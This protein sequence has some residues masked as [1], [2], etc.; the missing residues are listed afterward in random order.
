MRSLAGTHASSEDTG[1]GVLD[2]SVAILDAVERGARTFTEIRD[3]TGYTKS[4]THR[5][6]A[7]LEAHAFLTFVGGQGYRF[8]PR[9]LRF[10]TTAMRDLPLRDLARTALVRLA[11]ATGESAQLYVLGG[12]RRICVDSVES[13]SELRTIVMPGV[14]LPLMKGS[15]GKILLA[16]SSQPELDWILANAARRTPPETVPD[17]LM[18]QIVTAR[19]RGWS[20]SVGEREP[21]V[22]SVSA[23]VLN[24]DGVLIAAVSLSG[25]DTRLGRI[26]AGRLAPAVVAAAHEIQG[27][28]GY[29]R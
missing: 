17:N 11:E 14:V 27:A 2:R 25:P 23:P 24:D 22:A 21:G 12:D 18:Q 7:S 13:A 16:F 19:R 4:T 1:V 6:V 9:L 8:G 15:A 20:N 26:A 5:L 3:A 29:R 10:G 28:L